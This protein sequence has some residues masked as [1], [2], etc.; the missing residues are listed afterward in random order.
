MTDDEK[1]M[2]VE[3]DQRSQSNTHQIEDIKLDIKQI[4]EDQKAIYDLTSSVKVIADNIINMKEDIKDIKNSQKESSEKT[5]RQ[6]KN[7][8]DD[9]IVIDKKIDDL[10]NADALKAYQR[11]GSIKDKIILVLS[12]GLVT[13]VLDKILSLFR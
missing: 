12:G 13:F 4:K 8:E 9:Q 6:I 2:L 3:S 11:W 10:S 1:V 5:D 7:M